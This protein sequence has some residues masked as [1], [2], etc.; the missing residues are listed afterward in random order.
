VSTRPPLTTPRL[1]R[2]VARRVPRA[3]FRFVMPTR[4]WRGPFR[5]WLSVVAAD[6]DRRRAVRELLELEAATRRQLDAAAIRY[7]DG[8]HAKHRLTAYHD[9]FVERVRPGERVLDVGSGKG[10]LAHDLVLRAGAEVVGVDHDPHHLAFARERFRHE[11]LT[12]LDGDVLEAVP[13]GAFDV[14]VLSNVLE[15]IADRVGLLRR[16]VGE[17]RPRVVLLRV[18]VLA[19]DWTVPLRRE[20]GL[21]HFSDP[22]HEIEYDEEGFRA[23][24]AEAGLRVTELKLVWGE[25]WAAAEPAG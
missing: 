24:L 4:L 21:E 13:P 10:E 25:I 8:V 18:P 19:R 3:P 6:P 14:I 22:D 1:V 20:L 16:L 17:A 7:D 5:F 23:E 9:F 12:F 15:H 2:G 11:R